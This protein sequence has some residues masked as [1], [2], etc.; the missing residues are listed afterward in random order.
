MHRGEQWDRNN[1]DVNNIFD[2]QVA[3]DII[4]NDDDPKPQNTNECRQRND[5]PKWREAMQEK[6]HSRCFW[7]C[8]PN[9]CK[10]KT[11]WEQMSIC[12]K[13]Q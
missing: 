9:T 8:S 4:Q 12:T 5:W 13:A 7:T 10:Y 11:C 6:L 1:F 2:F 3:L